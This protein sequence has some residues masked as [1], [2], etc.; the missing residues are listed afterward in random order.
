MRLPLLGL[1]AAALLTG[2]VSPAVASPTPPTTAQVT[3]VSTSDLHGHVH[4]WDYYTNGEYDDAAHNDV[5]LAKAATLVRRIRAERGA[6]NTLLLDSGDTIQGTPM[7]YYYAKV[8]PITKTGA[9]HPMA[10]AMNAL[11]Y[12]AITLGNHEFNYGLPHLATWVD[13]LR[14]P[15][16]AANAV[17]AAGPLAGLPAYRPFVLKRIPVKGA[18]PVTVGVLGLTN[19]GVAVWDKAHVAGK[20]RFLDLVE[21]ARKWVPV[22]KRAGADVV[23][24]SAHAGDNGVS[25]Y[26]R[27]LPIENASAMVAEQVPDIDAVVFGHA[28]VDVGQRFV[29]NRVTGRQVVLSEPSKYGQRLSVVDLK[30]ARDGWRWQVTGSSARTLNTNTVA[31]DP[32]VA[33]SVRRQHARTVKYVNQVVAESST[34]LSAAKSRYLDTPIVD[35]IQQVQTE[36]VR[37]ALA[38]GQYADLPVISSTAPFSRTA[39][40]PAGRVSIRDLA[41]L[42]PYD[43]TLKAVVLTGAQLRDYL[44]RSARYFVQT[45]AGAPVDPEKLTGAGGEPD[46]NYDTLTGVEY[47]LDVARPA[48]QRVVALRYAGRP[49]AAGDRFVV[50]LNNYRQSG[51]GNFPHVAT[52]PVVYDAQTEIRQAL[53]DYAAS[54]GTIDPAGFAVVNWRLVR[55]GV[56][57][58]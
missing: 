41:A 2:T 22:L 39:R 26:G 10:A 8:E 20:L 33:A 21:T 56:P 43:N 29:T 1:A 55:A 19:P 12:D 4:N 54:V 15:V 37:R 53:I 45:P 48:G 11:G 31:E 58:F 38:G 46:Y 17:N 13:Q 5:G 16:L 30:L 32:K 18:P 52:A 36:A 25:S 23:V 7:A 57:V 3:V 14:A 24:V 51:G 28:H 47:D 40:I 34:E 35:Y 49:V 50:A 27:E 9:T 42:Y 6:R 44:E